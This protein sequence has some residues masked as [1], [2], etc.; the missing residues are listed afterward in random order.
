VVTVDEYVEFCS[1]VRRLTGVDLSAYKRKQM[2]RR[3][4]SFVQRNGAPSLGGYLHVLEGDEGELDGFLDRIT[5]NI[6]EL[7]RNPDRYETLRT[8]VLPEITAGLRP[9]RVW[10]AGCSYGAEAYTL[11]CMLAEVL[12]A[13]SPFEVVGSDI[14]AG[15]WPGRRGAGSPRPTCATCRSTS[16]TA[17][18]I[19]PTA[20]SRRV[21]SCARISGSGSR[22]CS[23]IG[24][25]PAGI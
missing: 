7:Y 19:R 6:S 23:R 25:D 4:R 8:A 18:S 12:P 13:T 24:P 20:V 17:G 14:P 21:P 22:T 5:I 10:S 16:G 3:I 1:G 15:S 11:A 9:P 2:E